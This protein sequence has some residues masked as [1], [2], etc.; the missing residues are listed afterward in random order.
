MKYILIALLIMPFIALAEDAPL[1]TTFISQ[2][3]G[4]RY[5]TRLEP[6]MV[7]RAGGQ[8]NYQDGNRSY[9]SEPKG[10]PLV[11]ALAKAEKE[12][13]RILGDAYTGK[14][15]KWILRSAERKS[16]GDSASYGYYYHFSY[17]TRDGAYSHADW[18]GPYG[19]L[20]IVVLL[21][22]NMLEVKRVE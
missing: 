7:R 20:Q 10:I 2:V 6:E 17:C 1:A 15:S 11:E 13:T 19:N 16:L 9:V 5:E 21:D 8:I 12:A 14:E 4:V 18:V 3:D 22:G